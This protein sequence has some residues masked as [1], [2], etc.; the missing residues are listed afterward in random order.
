[1][2]FGDG[3]LLFDVFG[4]SGEVHMVMKLQYTPELVMLSADNELIEEES[5]EYLEEDPRRIHKMVQR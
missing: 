2:G 5:E 1:L 3:I 4:D